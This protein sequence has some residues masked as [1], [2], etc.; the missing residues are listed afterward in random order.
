MLLDVVM[1]SKDG[2]TVCSELKCNYEFKNLPIIMVTARTEAKYLKTA[3]EIGAFDYIRKPVDAIEVAARIKSALR[4]MEYQGKA[5]GN[6]YEGW[7][8]R[9]L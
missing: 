6:G 4:Y 3:L 5:G 7:V 8:N 1:H 2:F 9:P